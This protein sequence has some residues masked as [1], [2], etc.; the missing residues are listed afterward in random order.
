MF[1]ILS[2]VALWDI[3]T[4]CRSAILFTFVQHIYLM[5]FHPCCHA[6][7]FCT[8]FAW[9]FPKHSINVRMF[10]D[11]SRKTLFQKH[12]LASFLQCIFHEQF[13]QDLLR[14]TDKLKLRHPVNVKM[15]FVWQTDMES[16]DWCVCTL[17]KEL[18]WW[19]SANNDACVLL[20][21][22]SHNF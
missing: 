22:Y 10:S 15:H 8:D 13:C 2:I 21:V 20:L 6:I 4:I 12:H 14:L 17:Y 19:S 3:C 11:R 16:S 7:Y 5:I 9:K 18:Y 1:I